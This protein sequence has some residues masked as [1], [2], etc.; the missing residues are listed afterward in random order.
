M[1]EAKKQTF[2]ESMQGA[3]DYQR[4]KLLKM[5]RAIVPTLTPEDILQP[6]DYLELEQNPCFRYEE[7]V[8]QGMLT[9]QMLYQRENRN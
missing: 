4:E 1:L 7:G 3:I 9:L 6:N 8:L 2:F 5:G